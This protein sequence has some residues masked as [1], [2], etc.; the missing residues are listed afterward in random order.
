[1]LTQV[2]AV[3]LVVVE[4]GVV[5][6]VDAAADVVV[7]VAVVAESDI[8][9]HDM[10]PDRITFQW[11]IT[12][13]CNYRCKHCYQDSYLYDGVDYPGM[14]DFYKKLEDFVLHFNDGKKRL[15]A[16]INFTGGEPFMKTGL[17]DLLEVVKRNRVFSYGILSNGFLLPESDLLR[18]KSLNPR[19]IQISLDGSESIHDSI[20]G[21]GSFKE[22]VKAI[23]AYNALKIPVLLSFTANAQNYQSFSEVVRIARKYNVYKLWTDRYLPSGSNDDLTLNSAQVKDFF[24]NILREQ[25][26]KLASRFSKTIISSSRSLQFLVTGGQPYSCSA[27]STLLAILSNG[28]IL[29]CRRLPIKI[30]NLITDSLIDIYQ[31]NSILK[32]LRR[33]DNLDDA[34]KQCYYCKSCGGGLKC[35]SFADSGDYNKKDPNCWL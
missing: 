22:V 25:K 4:A 26:S 24:E 21:I 6:V 5:V 8:K 10:I 28:D 13:V 3:V 29:P 31:N 9:N 34:C 32:E 20:R 17:L 2:L 14:L 19:F 27:G 35:L 16:H 12:E 11:H 15:S 23:K 33:N 30:G 1:M 7:V 18:L